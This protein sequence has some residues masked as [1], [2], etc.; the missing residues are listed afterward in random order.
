M[1]L[2]SLQGEIS[3]SPD[4]LLSFKSLPVQ[5]E[6]IFNHNVTMFPLIELPSKL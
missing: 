3:V 1:T 4:F 2:K 5:V 6:A